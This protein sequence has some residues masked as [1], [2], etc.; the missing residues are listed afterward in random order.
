MATNRNLCLRPLVLTFFLV[1]TS[2]VLFGQTKA[3]S[4]WMANMTRKI[5]QKESEGKY[6]EARTLIDSLMVFTKKMNYLKKTGDCYFNHALIDKSTGNKKALLQ[7][8]NQSIDYY[9]EAKEWKSAAKSYTIIG[10]TFMNDDYSLASKNFLKSYE[11]REKINDSSGMLNNLINLGG[12]SYQTGNYSLSSDYFYQ[13]LRIADNLKNNGLTAMICSN[14]SNIHNKTRNYE[15]SFEYLDRALQIYKASGNQKGESNVLMNQG[16]THFE[17]ENFGKAKECFEKSLEIKK[18]LNNDESGLI[19]IYNNL[20]VMAKRAGDTIQAMKY[21][22]NSLALSRKIGD[23][24]GIAI[25][26]NNLGSRNLDK[27]SDTALQQLEESLYRSQQMNLKKLVLI[28]YD[29]LKTYFAEQGDFKNA[30]RYASLYQT[31]ADSMYNEESAQAIIELQTR[32]DTEM[33]EKENQILKDQARIL[34]LNNL[35]LLISVIASV[36]LASFFLYLYFL[37]RK[38]LIQTSKLRQQENMLHELERDK[39]EKE[40]LHLQ[41]VLFA[42]EEIN[43]LQLMQLQEKNRE[44]STSAIHIINKNEVLGNIKTLAE[45]ALPGIDEQRKPIIRNLIREIDQNINLDEQ[46]EQ[47]KKHFESVHTGFFSRL[48]ER[49]P[50]LTQNEL[51]LCAYLRM[52]LSSKEI[53]QMLNISIESATTKRYRLRKKLL[54]SNEENLV[55]Y[56]AEF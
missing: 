51:K 19:K 43:R 17:M 38:S 52:N 6:D 11:L 28:N 22:S 53:A 45:A 54:L 44:L 31:L 41:E 8:L 46:W 47:F 37:K 20:G 27:K 23:K 30:L 56:L 3:D 26:M 36:I 29:N 18:L 40:N 42:E 55:N 35:L 32:Y 12:M 33:K 25:A 48:A 7:N 2:D 16:I 21:Y 24:Q 34:Q 1:L 10:Q 50:A 13:A 49:F 15:K 14:L 9:L 5:D 39:A 4:A